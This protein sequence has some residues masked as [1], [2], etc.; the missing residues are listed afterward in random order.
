MKQFT[1]R[2]PDEL[3]ARL[4]RMRGNGYWIGKYIVALIEK[5]LPEKEAEIAY[6]KR[7]DKYLAKAREEFA[8][9]EQEIENSATPSLSK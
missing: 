9:M 5:H 6:I 8:I 2:M 7:E 1:L 4:K 3:H